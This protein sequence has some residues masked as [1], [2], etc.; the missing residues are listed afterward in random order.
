MLKLFLTFISDQNK[1][2]L[3]VFVLP[4]SFNFN[5]RSKQKELR[6]K[7]IKLMCSPN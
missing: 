2:N 5:Y 6:K 1:L 3:R 7:E 4:S